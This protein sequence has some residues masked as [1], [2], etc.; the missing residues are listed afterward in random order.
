MNDFKKS[1]EVLNHLFGQDS[2]F[3]LATAKGDVPSVRVVDVYYENEKFY[4]VTYKNTRKVREIEMNPNVHI[5]RELYRFSGTAVNLGHPLKKENAKIRE[6]LVSVFEKWY[7]DHNDEH[8]ENMCYLEI[9]PKE[10]FFFKD[11]VG[12]SVDFVLKKAEHFP[13]D[14]NPEIV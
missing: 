2:Q 4:V 3:S 9:T 11:G 6:Q 7:F 1:L 10:G 12:Y 14:F 13:F 8:D 5:C